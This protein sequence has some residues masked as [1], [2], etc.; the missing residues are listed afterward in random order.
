MYKLL[1]LNYIEI[2]IST[3][4]FERLLNCLKENIA[5]KSSY[6]LFPDFTKTLIS[7]TIE[8]NKIHELFIKKKVKF[9]NKSSTNNIKVYIYKD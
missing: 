7:L 5:K 3:K 1:F 2:N 9:L 8:K 4:N 6:L